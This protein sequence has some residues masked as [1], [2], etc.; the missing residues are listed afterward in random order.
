MNPVIIISLFQ[1]VIKN[2]P[3]ETKREIDKQID[4]VEDRFKQGSLL[5]IATEQAMKVLRGQLDIKD[6]EDEVK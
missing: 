4:K 3:E 1:E 2:L 5:D 6:Y